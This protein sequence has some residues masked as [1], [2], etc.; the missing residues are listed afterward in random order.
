MPSI[1]DVPV[2]VWLD[3]FEYLDIADLYTFNTVFRGTLF[4]VIAQAARKLVKK[5]LV[6]AKPILESYLVSS[7]FHFPL[8]FDAGK[9]LARPGGPMPCSLMLRECVSRTFRKNELNSTEMTF[10]FDFTTW[11]D[12]IIGDLIFEPCRHGPEPAELV[13]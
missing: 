3:I 4:W 9:F 10:Q 5:F 6:S 11:V 2:E 12:K 8:E 7:E 13:Y 1:Q